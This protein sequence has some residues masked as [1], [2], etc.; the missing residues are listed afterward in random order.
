VVSPSSVGRIWQA[1]GLK[2]WLTDTVKLS[3]DPQF[4]DKVRDVVGIYMNPPEP[5]WRQPLGRR[6]RRFDARRTRGY[7][8]CSASASALPVEDGGNRGPA[9][10][11]LRSR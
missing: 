3:D 6:S 11:V 7:S 1:F 2:P 8:R 9:Q 5:R 10:S 4:I